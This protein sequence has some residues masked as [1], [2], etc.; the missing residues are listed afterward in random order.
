LTLW[1]GDVWGL[2]GEKEEGEES[3][4]A[5]G[6]VQTHFIPDAIQEVFVDMIKWIQI[7]QRE[8]ILKREFCNELK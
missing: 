7:K 8:Q 6:G 3:P 5:L 1:W 2:E 4:R